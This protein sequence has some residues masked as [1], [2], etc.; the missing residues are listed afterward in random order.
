[1]KKLLLIFLMLFTTGFISQ[2]QNYIFSHVEQPYN[3]LTSAITLNTNSWFYNNYHIP[4]PF[5]ITI[6]E[7]EVKNIYLNNGILYADSKNTA[8][9]QYQ[10]IA[11]SAELLDPGYVFNPGA[12][13]SSS[14]TFL[15]YKVEG[16]TGNRILKIEIPNAANGNEYFEKDTKTMRINF[17]VWFYENNDLIEYRYGRNTMTNFNLFFNDYSISEVQTPK[18]E[19]MIAKTAAIRNEFA[20]EEN[21]L[22]AAYSLSGTSENPK[23][24]FSVEKLGTLST[25]PKN[26]TVYQFKKARLETAKKTTERIVLSP[27]PTSDYLN[28]SLDNNTNRVNYS[29]FDML[30]KTVQSGV[31]QSLGSPISVS[32]LNPGIYLI[33]IENYKTLKFIKR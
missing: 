20:D 26:G 11:Q 23:G 15:K 7:D 24:S 10:L 25:Y 18:F 2:A 30:G 21:E 14:E 22:V 19:V 16:E 32:N 28:I 4:I 6:L 8:K 17:Q 12:P 33:K 29:I 9:I 13:E 1:M 27:N 3:E 31:Y 5:R